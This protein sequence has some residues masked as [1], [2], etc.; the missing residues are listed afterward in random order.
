[1]SKA[2]L[3]ILERRLRPIYDSLDSQNYKKAFAECE[4]VLKKHPATTAA[5]VLKAL[6]LVRL[7]K[8]ADAMEITDALDVAGVHHDEFTLQA[9][10][11]C[12]RDSNQHMKVV[13]LYEKIIQVDP[14]ENNLTQLF[15]AYSRERMYKEQQKI[16]LR[17]YK[18]LNVTTYYYWSVMSLILQAKENPELGKK[19]L[20]PLAEKMCE[21]QIA[22]TGYTEGA[23][24]ELEL[25]L[26]ILEGQEKWKEC[27]EF[28]DR[29]EAASLPMAPYN[30]VEKVMA[31]LMKDEQYAKASEL[32]VGVVENMPDN[33]NI[34][35]IIISA[36]LSQVEQLVGSENEED[37]ESA[38]SL[39]KTL[40]DLIGR[41]QSKSEFKHRA[42][43]IVP[44]FA[45]MK[46]GEISRKIPGMEDLTPIFGDKV[47]K[48]LLYVEK[49]YTK[50]VC[51]AD[52][53]L[54]FKDMTDEQK[55]EFL[56]GLTSW[57]SGI[58]AAEQA[59]G[60]ESKVWA[61]IL[62]ERCRRALGEYDKMTADDHRS[63]FQQFIA[64]IAAKGRSEH[65]QGVLCNFTT[66]HLW[67]A[68]RK[69][70]DAE[71]FYEM[72]LLLEFVATTNRT[73]PL[74]KL[75]LVR[76]YSGLCAT[77]RISALVKTLDIKAIQLDT[78]GHMTFPIYETS[79]RF[80]LAIINNTQLTMMY[81]QAEKEIQDCIA[82][83]YRNGKFTAIPRM[84]AASQKMRLSAQKTAC[85]V[86]N[87]YLSSLFVLDDI[88]QI[89]V[90]LWGD[91][92]PIGEKRIDW[93]QL[94]DTRDFTV[95]PYT[96]TSDY[97]NLLEDM[98]K[99]TFQ[100]LIDISE[101][102]STM[103]RALGAVGRVT[104]DNMEPRLARLQLKMTVMEY[105]NHLEHCCKEYPS[106]LIPS[107]LAQ[108]PAPQHLAQW[109]HSG[110]PQ[111]ILEYLEAAVKLVD[112]LDS[113]EHPD[114]SLV[115]TRTEMAKK[116]IKLIEV[117]PRR[118]EGEKLPSFWMVDSIIKSS[119]ALQTIAAIQV[120]LRL[121]E[122]VVLKLA[123]NVPTA[124]P[125]SLSK[126]KGKKEK[127]AA[128]E[129]IAKALD[130]CKAVVFLEHIRAKH[131]ELRSAGNFLH[132]H[133]SQM[134][135]YEDKHVPTNVGE[136]LGKAQL[137][138]QEM[139]PSVESRLQRS[140]LNAF[141]D[142][143]TTIKSRF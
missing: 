103:C 121:I 115:G 119:R 3:A 134:L 114:I 118:E 139:S 101:L 14:S 140:Y 92:D 20:L 67:D 66:A 85:E 8:V 113:G 4:K 64:Q 130:E 5:K 55:Q 45:H 29:G 112:I 38:R 86:M 52:L 18:D 39:I 42:P 93:K 11:H 124:A 57:M 135:A 36:T 70:N 109:V 97:E 69:E 23:S 88:D 89:T 32:A 71:K 90:T 21:T 99:R 120:V 34:W 94:I 128:E 127:K 117:P 46:L 102:R 68:Y 82:Q 1:M 75:G 105:K 78:M 53:Q 56:K 96:E 110:G 19:M 125:E 73:D 65:A 72:I 30:L 62:M 63:L 15:M 98:K 107:K 22:K 6:T 60:D 132:S 2:E 143:H 50:P 51:F 41:I 106:F 129:A 17:L 13:S 49:F 76:A 54:Y 126:P 59:E 133:F 40:G 104:H 136:G 44:F 137:V 138:L 108:S 7:D 35:K 111:M 48:M 43:Y 58:S 27:A 95:I 33:W 91:E 12:Y 131:V 28:V 9:F 24:A 77:G 83:S 116:L 100:E 81:E 87:R 16:G 47:K 80:N 123:K 84:A 79:G 61:I 25:E 37:I 31:Y 26:L 122:K 74:C 142:M 141:E 10:V